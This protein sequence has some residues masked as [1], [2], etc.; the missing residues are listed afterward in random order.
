MKPIRVSVGCLATAFA[1]TGAVQADPVILSHPQSHTTSVGSDVTFFV[2]ATGTEPL[3][4]QWRKDAVDIDGE[5]GS[6][7]SIMD[8]AL[9]DAGAYDVTLSN[10]FGT[11]TSNPAF[12]TVVPE[13]SS[14]AL[15]GTGLVG[16]LACGWR[17]RGRG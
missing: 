11:A 8:V 13:P 17:R 9:S 5:T 2:E 16:L 1:L 12:L 7:L 14:Y 4:Y 10:A 15:L 6:S 3:F